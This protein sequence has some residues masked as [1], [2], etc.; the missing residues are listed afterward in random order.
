M[1]SGTSTILQLYKF[2]DGTSVDHTIDRE[3]SALSGDGQSYHF[4]VRKGS[5][6]G[7]E[8][9]YANINFDLSSQALSVT[10]G[11]TS[12]ATYDGSEG[13]SFDISSATLTITQDGQTLA[14]YDGTSD[15]SVDLSSSSSSLSGITVTGTD[16]SSATCKD[17]LTFATTSDSNV[18]V[19]VSQNG[20]DGV[21][22]SIGVYYI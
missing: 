18:K 14:T 22:V 21:K 2:A 19:S 13:V 4:L 20:V 15:I 1:S 8:I 6:V 3:N 17:A 11:G 5:D 10:R 7:N 9:E 16:G 12:I